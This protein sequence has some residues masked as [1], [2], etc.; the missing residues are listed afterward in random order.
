MLPRPLAWLLLCLIGWGTTPL[1]ARPRLLSPAATVRLVTCAPG[2]EAYALFGHSALR[3]TD[4]RQGL[5]HVYNYGTFDFHTPNFYGRFLRGDLRYFLSATSFATFCAAYQAEQRP[6]TEQVLALQPAE[7]QRVYDELEATLAS[8]ARFYRYQFFADNCTTRLYEL[9]TRSVTGSLQLDSTYIPAGQTYRQLLAPYLAPAPWV[10]VGMNLGLGWPADQPTV[11]RQR[12]FLPT[13]LSQAWAHTS[14]QHRPFVTRTRSLFAAPILSEQSPGWATPGRVLGSLA[15]LFALAASLP[16]RYSLLA[17]V[18]GR[19]VLAV[20][21]LTG[22]LI[23]GLQLFSLHTP[24]HYNYQL[25]WLL[26]THLLVAVSPVRRWWRP[27]AAGAIGLL[28]V[29]S[30]L[31]YGVY[32]ARLLPEIGWLLGVL[33]GQLLLLRKQP[34]GVVQ[35]TGA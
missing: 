33:F 31:G 35:Q 8:P 29:G 26:P 34:F 3:I 32:Y 25:L 6:L 12:L 11:F 30:L 21:G 20:V 16:A 19:G 10:K 28:V 23:A 1:A 7:T 13:E 15:I 9:I 24:A 5:D 22:C 18:L 27:Y 4:P 2:T 17:A 14:R